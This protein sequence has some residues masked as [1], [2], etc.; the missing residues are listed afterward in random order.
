MMSN[1]SHQ[2]DWT[3]TI[4]VRQAECRLHVAAV[5]HVVYKCTYLP[6][7]LT[8]IIKFKRI[9]YRRKNTNNSDAPQRFLKCRIILFVH[10][11]KSFNRIF[12]YRFLI[13][14][15]RSST[16]A[17]PAS[18]LRSETTFRRIF[19]F[20]I[21]LTCKILFLK[22]KKKGEPTGLCLGDSPVW[23]CCL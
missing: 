7:I 18:D 15:C 14:R 6:I 19:F 1:I 21:S 2:T 3:E 4:K 11:W 23:L 16:H 8:H 22:S 13:L 9:N 12:S 17:L 10:N 20:L 5:S